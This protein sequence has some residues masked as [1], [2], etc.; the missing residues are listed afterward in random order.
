ML[1]RLPLV[2]MLFGAAHAEPTPSTG[3]DARPYLSPSLFLTTGSWGEVLPGET[4]PTD[5]GGISLRFAIGGLFTEREEGL[6]F[7]AGLTVL[8]ATTMFSGP[9]IDTAFHP[10]GG[11]GVELEADHPVAT[12]ER[13]GARVGWETTFGSTHDLSGSLLSFGG[14]YYPSDDVWLG[15]DVCRF[16]PHR[17][18]SACGTA[19]EQAGDCAFKATGVLVGLGLEGR[20]GTRIGIGVGV[21]ALLGFLVLAGQAH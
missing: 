10:M 9:G 3:W 8:G 11:V 13:L 19:A 6:R 16:A 15:V 20:A 21:V 17:S 12:G 1:R 7:H 4:R 18:A 5:A 14:R 2:V